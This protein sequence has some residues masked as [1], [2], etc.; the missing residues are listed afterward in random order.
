M[1]ADHE[2]RGAVGFWPVVAPDRR[3]VVAPSAWAADQQ[4]GSAAHFR[5]VPCSARALLSHDHYSL[6]CFAFIR[7]PLRALAGLATPAPP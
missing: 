5:L 7:P 2:V 3:A 4:A 1:H 6:P